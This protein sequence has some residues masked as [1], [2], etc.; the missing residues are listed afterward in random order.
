MEAGSKKNSWSGDDNASVPE[1][2][3]RDNIRVIPSAL[4]YVEEMQ[5][6]LFLIY[7]V[8]SDDYEDLFTAEMFGQHL[9]VFPEGQFIALD[10]EAER[11]VGITV[12]MRMNF[13]AS[14]PFVE[15][16][17]TTTGYG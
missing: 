14:R 6:L 2:S 8:T 13:D 7:D 1:R 3:K 11:I 17:V 9:Q 16:W 12:S 10:S 4:E 5:D 15:P